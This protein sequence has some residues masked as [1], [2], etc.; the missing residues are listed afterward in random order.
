MQ[1]IGLLIVSKGIGNQVGTHFKGLL[2]F[3]FGVVM[4]ALI[5]PAI[6]LSSQSVL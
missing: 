5:F 3:G 6:L 4:D 1:F 2:P